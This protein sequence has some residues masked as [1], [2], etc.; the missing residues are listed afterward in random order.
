MLAS[1]AISY[2][3]PPPYDDTAL[4]ERAKSAVEDGIQVSAAIPTLEESKA[5]FGVDLMRRNIQPL[6]LEIRNDTDRQM[7]FVPTGLDPEYFSPLEVA[8]GFHKPYNDQGRERFNR[9]IESTAIRLRID[10]HS[11]VS[12]FL[13]TNPDEDSKL[14]TVDLFGLKWTRSI[15]L[16]VPTAD[17]EIVEGYYERLIKTRERLGYVDVEDESRLREALERL[18][19]CTTGPNGQKGEPLNLVLIGALPETGAAFIRRNYRVDTAA[20]WYVFDRPQDLTLSKRDRWVPAQPHVMRAWLTNIRF[21]G[22]PVW[23]AQVSTPLGGRFA[24]EIISDAGPRIDPNVDEARID[25]VQDMI[26]SQHLARLGFV[27]GVGRVMQSAPR[28]TSAGGT[29]YTDGL[30]AVLFFENRPVSISEIQFL[31]WERLV[32]HFRKQIDGKDGAKVR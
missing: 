7:F 8:Y 2:Q 14:V 9:Y 25:L 6:W 5:I 24:S 31:P 18:P 16:I 20:P 11:T 3:R 19:C 29:Y 1:C 21:R 13:F 32:D 15:T 22:R 4:R 17:R 28:E 10:P 26:Y 12:G 23:I 30:R 27:E